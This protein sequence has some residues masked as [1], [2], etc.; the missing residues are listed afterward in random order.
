MSFGKYQF[1]PWSRR[2]VSAYIEEADTLGKTNGAAVERA[3]VS[4]TVDVNANMHEQKKFLLLG[5]GDISGIQSD[6]IIR[7]EPLD[8]IANF[9]PNYLPFIEFYDED[10]PWRYTPA[11]ATGGNELNLRPW[12]ALIVLR[13]DEFS[14]TKRRKPLSSITVLN[15]DALPPHD[16]LHLWAHTHFN[17]SR[18]KQTQF[19]DFLDDLKEDAKTDPDGLFSR[20]ICPRHLTSNTLYHVFL[21][22][23]YETGRL[24]GLGR[25]IKGVKAQQPSWGAGSDGELPVYYRWFFRTGDNFDF[26]YLVKLLEPR[27]MDKRVG[28]RPMDCGM[29]GFVQADQPPLPDT[30]L[31]PA[32]VGTNPK[33]MLLEG[34]LK[35]PSAESTAFSTDKNV[36]PFLPQLE[37]LVNL[38][39]IQYEKPNEDPYVT[40]PFY[41]MYHAMVKDLVNPQKKVLP[42]FDADSDIWYD[43]LNRDPRTRVP[44]GFGVRMV[45][46]NQEKFMDLAWKQLKDVLEANRKMNAIQFT[47]KVSERLY[48]KHVA[49]LPDDKLLSVSRPL[50]ARVLAGAVTAKYS[51]QES[52]VPGAVFSHPFRRSTRNQ[53]AL[54]RGLAPHIQDLRERRALAGEEGQSGFNLKNLINGLNAEGDFRLTAAPRVNFQVVGELDTTEPFAVPESLNQIQVWSLQSN[55]DSTYICNQTDFQGGLPA[56]DKWNFFFGPAIFTAGGLDVIPGSNILGGGDIIIF[57]PGFGGILGGP[58]IVVPRAAAQPLS[59]YTT[60][61]VSL[62]DRVGFA[63]TMVTPG[64]LPVTSV[65]THTLEYVRPGAAFQ[66]F[67]QKAIIPGPGLK[68]AKDSTPEDFLPA[69]AYPDF[70]EP[71]YEYLVKIDKELLIPNLELIP[72]NTKSLLRTNQKF[73]EAYMV[74][75]NYEM[76]REMLWREYPTDMRGSYFR[77][78]WDV[79]GFV[80]PNAEAA[81]T[82]SKKDIKP[83]D[84]W[85][86]TEKLGDHNAQEP[87]GDAEQLVFVIRG[88][89]LKKFP[90]T[91]IYAQKAIAK[92]DKDGNDV[93]DAEGNVI[94]VIRSSEVEVGAGETPTPEQIN[95]LEKDLEKE[96]MFPIYKADIQPDIK[97]LGFDLTI[98]QAAGVDENAFPSGKDFGDTLGWF[99]II[100]EVPGEPRFGM[101]LTY[102]PT[103]PVVGPFS[104]NDLSW[105]NFGGQNLEF[106]LGTQMPGDT[107]TGKK[108]T[109]PNTDKEGTW[110]RSS[111]DMAA[112]LFQRPVMIATHATEMLD[113]AVIDDAKG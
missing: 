58:G 14:D 38:N 88:E 63:E 102:N 3:E 81:D 5:P 59:D 112:A 96:I 39:L 92:K 44:A 42:T 87:D 8:G 107:G 104:W 29:P 46:E 15:P 99:F 1:L 66:R 93:K 79:S 35:A 98:E 50:S 17:M 37:K 111:A 64:P 89:L 91:V 105:E 19:E 28:M 21:V 11:H 72:P 76:G 52:R 47:A 23:A 31:P 97:L 60:A 48:A 103:H 41:G 25:S 71:S 34:A 61:Y 62:N 10:F 86:K 68:T 77:Q 9:E 75:L 100:A 33:I 54:V 110:N 22:P 70:P 74:G 95:Q 113:Q 51:V 57:D 53:T 49:T 13:E 106:V 27:V 83:I 45:Q 43:D 40:V 55:L 2:G 20:L 108:F 69:M 80:T 12:L 4:I 78:F 7:T 85:L 6:M 101:D 26:E 90:N 24:A 73:I 18:E 109:P 36:Q 56:V 82:E 65:A 30:G 84:T 16:E 67:V 94:K 32:V